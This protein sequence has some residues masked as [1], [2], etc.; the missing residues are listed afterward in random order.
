VIIVVEP[1][2]DSRDAYFL[3]RAQRRKEPQRPLQIRLIPP[4]GLC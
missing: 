1:V 2:D 4:A 3:A